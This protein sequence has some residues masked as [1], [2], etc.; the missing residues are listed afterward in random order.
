VWRSLIFNLGSEATALASRASS[1]QGMPSAVGFPLY[2]VSPQFMP[3]PLAEAKIGDEPKG[4]GS[5][6]YS[7]Y[8]GPRGTSKK[9]M[10][11]NPRVLAQW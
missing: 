8:L 4:D 3:L 10:G 7:P 5:V 11:S 2:T 1:N 9:F 6:A